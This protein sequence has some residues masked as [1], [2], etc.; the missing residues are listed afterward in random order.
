M[1]HTR[2]TKAAGDGAH[3][4]ASNGDGEE[5]EEDAPANEIVPDVHGER[6]AAKPEEDDEL[7]PTSRERTRRISGS[8]EAAST[9]SSAKSADRIS[10]AE[11]LER[12][13]SAADFAVFASCNGFA[14]GA[15]F[16]QPFSF[17]EYS[18]PTVRLS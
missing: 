9:P 13:G 6:E 1:R 14:D 16:L 11:F 8:S 7:E 10:R 12:G 18:M 3:D 2:H 15:F 5:Q 4:R 17:R